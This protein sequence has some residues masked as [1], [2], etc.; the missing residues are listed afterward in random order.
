MEECE[1]LCTRLAIMVNGS[2]KCLGSV[3]HLK[4][5]YCVHAMF[6][7]V[8]ANTLSFNL[9]HHRFSSG[10]TLQAKVNLASPPGEARVVR[11]PSRQQPAVARQRSRSGSHGYASLSEEP[12]SDER[13]CMCVILL[14]ILHAQGC[15]APA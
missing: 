12:H 4:N 5:K 9:Y 8:D 2:F 6:D 15:L 10:L 7:L 1:A 13:Y 14:T 11:S 3:Q